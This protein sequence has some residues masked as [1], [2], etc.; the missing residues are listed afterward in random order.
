MCYADLLC[1]HTSVLNLCA[2]K[3]IVAGSKLYCK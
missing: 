1:G 3:K 2:V